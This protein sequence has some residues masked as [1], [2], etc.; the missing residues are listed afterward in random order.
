VLLCFID[1]RVRKIRNEASSCPGIFSRTL[2]C[3]Y[4]ASSPGSPLSHRASICN[5]FLTRLLGL[6][7]KRSKIWRYGPTYVLLQSDL[8]I[9]LQENHQTSVQGLPARDRA[10]SF[11]NLIPRGT[12]VIDVTVKSILERVYLD[13]GLTP[14]YNPSQLSCAPTPPPLIHQLFLDFLL[15]GGPGV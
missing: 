15:Q 6:L 9:Y 7:E 2:R 12:K 4:V 14:I 3:Y 13:S 11:Y 10:A 1:P 5:T 8:E